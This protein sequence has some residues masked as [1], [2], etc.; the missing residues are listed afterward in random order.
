MGI[1]FKRYEVNVV[2]RLTGGDTCKGKIDLRGTVLSDMSD[3]EQT[4]IK[5]AEKQMREPVQEVISYTMKEV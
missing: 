1:F 2:L 3:V 4:I 5:L